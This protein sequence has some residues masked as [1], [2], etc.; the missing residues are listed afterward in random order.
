VTDKRVLMDQIMDYGDSI[1]AGE[2]LKSQLV[3]LEGIRDSLEEWERDFALAEV[4][5]RAQR[6]TR[7]FPSSESHAAPKRSDKGRTSFG[8]TG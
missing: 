3:H 8:G 7:S 4:S 6:A 5:G 1:R 2:P